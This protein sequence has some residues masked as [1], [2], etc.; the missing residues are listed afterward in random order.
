MNENA[1]NIFTNII[2]LTGITNKTID[3]LRDIEKKVILELR[4]HFKIMAIASPGKRLLSTCLR[5]I[6]ERKAPPTI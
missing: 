3:Q 1:R 4:R 6:Y 2:H 5:P